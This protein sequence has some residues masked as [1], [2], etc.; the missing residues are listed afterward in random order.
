MQQL[1]SAGAAPSRLPA[2]RLL[3]RASKFWTSRTKSRQRSKLAIDRHGM[4][5][6][7]RPGSAHLGQIQSHCV[8]I[9]STPMDICQATKRDLAICPNP[10]LFCRRTMTKGSDH[11]V[12]SLSHPRRQHGFP[13]SWSGQPACRH[14]RRTGR[15]LPHGPRR[16]GRSRRGA[17]ICAEPPHARWAGNRTDGHYQCATGLNGRQ[18]GRHARTGSRTGRGCVW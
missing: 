15:T 17:R 18:H 13:L 4:R 16:A 6:I 11:G 1:P 9:F 10:S 3:Q 8:R 2:L 12:F 14:G 7:D 5:L